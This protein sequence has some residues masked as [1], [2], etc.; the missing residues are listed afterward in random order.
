MGD[1]D[2]F[3]GR[4]GR[5]V[6][7]RVSGVCGCGG[8]GGWAW[9]SVGVSCG[10]GGSGDRAGF[11]GRSTAVGWGWGGV[12]AN[13]AGSTIP[14]WSSGR[15]APS[16]WSEGRDLV[17]EGVWGRGFGCARPNGHG[18]GEFG[19]DGLSRYEQGAVDWAVWTWPVW[20]APWIGTGVD[21]VCRSWPAECPAGCP[22]GGGAD[23]FGPGGWILVGGSGRRRS[24]TPSP[25][26]PP[27]VAWTRRYSVT[28]VRWCTPRKHT[29]FGLSPL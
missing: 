15:F 24:A 11:G 23:G 13:R 28:P 6:R 19:P 12:G 20:T 3:G 4:A 25:G 5:D 10:G 26:Q 8:V 21:T 14:V 17:G 18:S 29:H 22:F 7:A 2:G 9:G 1:L 27:M 16:L